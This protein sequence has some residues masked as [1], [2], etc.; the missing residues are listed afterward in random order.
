[1]LQRNIVILI[2]IC[3]LTGCSLFGAVKTEPSKTY[4]ISALPAVESKFPRTQATLLVLNIESD[5]IY[6]TT[7]M[8]Y[9]IYRYQLS[10]F[11][12][13]GWVKTPA[14]M[15]QPLIVEALQN[16]HYFH[17]VISSSAI[18]HY[19]YILSTKLLELREV[20]FPCS[21][22]IHLKLRAQIVKASDSTIVATREFFVTEPAPQ[23]TPYGGVV[24]ANR[25]VANMLAQ[26]VKFCLKTIP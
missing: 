11:A 4:V 8:A 14:Q 12:K 17:A 25:A 15:L 6:E 22:E 20:F 5:P 9:S 19:D 26:L 13:N 18:G 2:M 24:A 7:E 23:R 3:L 1:M 21:S 16:T 10:Y